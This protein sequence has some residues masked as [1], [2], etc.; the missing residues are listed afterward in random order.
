VNRRQT[1][2]PVRFPETNP[3]GKQEKTGQFSYISN[4]DILHQAMLAGRSIGFITQLRQI[5]VQHSV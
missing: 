2:A 3:N 5:F 4:L 1:I